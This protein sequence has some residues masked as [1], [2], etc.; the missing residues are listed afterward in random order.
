MSKMLVDHETYSSDPNV[1]RAIPEPMA[2]I[3]AGYVRPI[4]GT[5]DWIAEVPFIKIGNDRKFLPAHIVRKIW[6][7]RENLTSLVDD[8]TEVE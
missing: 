3:A 4:E 6:E 7:Y 1:G 8:N 2:K 5:N